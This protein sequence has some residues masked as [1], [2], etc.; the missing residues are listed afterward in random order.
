MRCISQDPE[1]EHWMSTPQAKMHTELICAAAILWACKLHIL[2]RKHAGL[3]HSLTHATNLQSSGRTSNC[4]PNS[5][6]VAS[7]VNLSISTTTAI[8]NASNLRLSAHAII[9]R[10]IMEHQPVVSLE[11][12][13]GEKALH[14][15]IWSYY[16][17]THTRTTNRIDSEIN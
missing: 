14:I 17:N 12:R 8:G 9:I 4:K 16:W 1:A 6:K 2:G 3:A 10:K 15:Y 13:A 7:Y 11:S 5:L